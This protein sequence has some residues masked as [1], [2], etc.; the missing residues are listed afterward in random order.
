[1]TLSPAFTIV[2]RPVITFLPASLMLERSC[3]AMPLITAFS[4]ATALLLPSRYVIVT[5]PLLSTVYSWPAVVG[6]I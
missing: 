3:L 2:P 4:L 5:S 1:M 6:A